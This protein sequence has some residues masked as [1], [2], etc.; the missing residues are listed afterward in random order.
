[1]NATA[2]LLTYSPIIQLRQQP[3]RKMRRSRDQSKLTMLNLKTT[4]IKH[5]NLE[6]EN[7]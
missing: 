3:P 1:M 7:C 6:T 4:I 2:S 5:G